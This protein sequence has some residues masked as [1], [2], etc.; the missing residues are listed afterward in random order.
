[1]PSPSRFAVTFIEIALA[2]S[3]L[4]SIFGKISFKNGESRRQITAV[5]PELSATAISPPQ[6]QI[7]PPSLMQRLTASEAAEITA[8]DK[9][10]AFPPKKAEIAEKITIP[11]Q[12]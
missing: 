7:V 6:R 8:F 11:A 1:M 3:P 12:I 9:A 2:V 4:I 10:C 5:N